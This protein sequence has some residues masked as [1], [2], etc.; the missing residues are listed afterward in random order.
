MV[1]VNEPHDG[2][3]DASRWFGFEENLASFGTLK[4]KRGRDKDVDRL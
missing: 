2:Q 3:T 4:R 1:F